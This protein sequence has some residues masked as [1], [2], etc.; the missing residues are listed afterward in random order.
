MRSVHCLTRNGR[1]VDGAQPARS[2]PRSVW[3]KP[4]E[5]SQRRGPVMG[6]A[7]MTLP[8]KDAGTGRKGR[9]E[10]NQSRQHG[11]LTRIQIDVQIVHSNAQLASH[12]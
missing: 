3:Q 12:H 8:D 2:R 10:L 6:E 5:G 9:R 11:Q 4:A 7:A 1:Q